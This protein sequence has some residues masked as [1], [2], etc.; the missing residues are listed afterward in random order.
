MLQVWNI[1][2]HLPEQNRH[3]IPY[4]GKY[5]IHRAYGECFFWTTKGDLDSED[6]WSLRTAFFR[7]FFSRHADMVKNGTSDGALKDWTSAKCGMSE[8][9]T[10]HHVWFFSTANHEFGL[11]FMISDTRGVSPVWLLYPW[12]PTK[13]NDVLV[14]YGFFCTNKNTLT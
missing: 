5:T 6:R 1:Y 3:T 10:P 8:S 9:W 4:V 2:Q 11:G 14:V 13:K 12:C 7:V